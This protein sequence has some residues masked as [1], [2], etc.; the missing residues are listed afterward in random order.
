MEKKVGVIGYG[1]IGREIIA[2]I[3]RQEIP[4]AKIVALFDKE[5]QVIAQSL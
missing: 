4:N 2:A 1:S 5:S 3:R